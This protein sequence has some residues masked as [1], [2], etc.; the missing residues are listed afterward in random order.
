MKGRPNNREL[1]A[2]PRNIRGARID[3]LRVL[4]AH[5]PHVRPRQ[6]IIDLLGKEKPADKRDAECHQRLDEPRTQLDSAWSIKAPLVFRCQCVMNETPPFSS[7]LFPSGKA[8]GRRRRNRRRRRRVG[9]S[10]A[11]LSPAPGERG[12]GATIAR[13]P[14]AG[15]DRGK[16]PHGLGRTGCLAARRIGGLGGVIRLRAVRLGVVRL[17]RVRLSGVRFGSHFVA[18]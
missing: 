5:H 12:S 17:G 1:G 3:E 16:P 14:G 9:D 2:G 15:C 18:S 10:P 11:I 7:L 6:N 13:T 4:R 8:A